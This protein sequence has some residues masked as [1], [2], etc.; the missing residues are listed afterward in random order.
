[1]K[2]YFIEK[3]FIKN[4]RDIENLRIFLDT[5]ERKHLI[6]TGKNGSGKTSLLLEIN[7]LLNKLIDNQFATIESRKNEV[8]SLLLQTKN[9]KIQI[10]QYQRQIDT[11]LKQKNNLTLVE[12]QTEPQIQQ[13]SDNIK[14]YNLLSAHF[15]LHFI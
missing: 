4:V 11:Q 13:L 14:S 1:M 6:I 5:T 12:E 2:N 7:T 3:I 9:I 8:K 10:E 15:K